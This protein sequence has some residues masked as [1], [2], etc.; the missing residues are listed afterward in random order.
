MMFM[1]KKFLYAEDSDV[2]VLGMPYKGED[3]HMFA[4]LPKEQ[5]GLSAFEKALTGERLLGY[6]R[7]AHKSEVEVCGHNHHLAR[8]LDISYFRFTFQSSSW[9]KV[10]N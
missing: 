8:S 10:S 3:L 2:Q 5:H 9:K 4:F 7:S 6:I 1:K